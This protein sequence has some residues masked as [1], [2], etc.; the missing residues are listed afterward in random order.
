MF[1]ARFHLVHEWR[2]FLFTDPGLPAELLRP[3]GRGGWPRSSSTTRRPG[4]SPA[5]TGS[6]PAA[7]PDRRTADCPA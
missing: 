2:K 4:W 1:A 6:W 7:W 5:P 3:A